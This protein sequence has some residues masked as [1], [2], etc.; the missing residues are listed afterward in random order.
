MQSGSLS[1]YGEH[2]SANT[3]FPCA[4]SWF[5]IMSILRNGKATAFDQRSACVSVDEYLN[6]LARSH[7]F[8]G[9]EDSL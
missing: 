9:A 1:I 2:N 4:T 3:I 8:S 6:N 7:D 5:G